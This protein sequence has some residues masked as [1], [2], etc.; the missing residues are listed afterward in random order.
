MDF[1]QFKQE[2]I[3]RIKDFLP[4]KYDDADVSIQS[5]VKNNDQK[6]DG[7]MIKTE[8]SNIAPNIYLNDF[9]K[10]LE[11]GR[12]MEDILKNIADI[13]VQNE[14]EQGF[15][16]NQITDFEQVKDKI[17]CRLVNLENNAEYLEGKPFTQIEDLAVT[18]AV[19]LSESSEGRMSVAI[20][21]NL[22]DSYGIT[23]DE[24]HQIAVD[25]IE[26]QHPEFMSMRDMLMQMMYPDGA[27][28][29]P[30]AQ[31]FLPPE[32]EKPSMYVLSNQSRVNGAAMVLDT[33]LMDDI[34]EKLGG[35]FI[36]LPSSVH[37]VIILP[38]TEEMDQRMLENM[39]QDVNA[40][41]VA[42]EE[43]LS[44]HVYAYDSQEHELI[45]ADKME[46]REQARAEKG[47]GKDKA[48][49]K[50]EMRGEKKADK[51]RTSFK[52]RL[53]EKMGEVAKN[54]AGREHPGKNLETS[55]G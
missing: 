22:M 29:D 6:L 34:A 16:V 33:K 47:L 9:F 38:K 41:Q 5:V 45:R 31:M 32:E 12:D 35:D 37:E 4:D 27:P 55:L 21:D 42:P 36:V 25:N 13:R 7:L 52:D 30:M 1:E 46:E 23:K 18:Y 54:E 26:N 24:L 53:A 51:E 20:T 49:R 14:M 40:G 15:D 11:D 8:D 48:E 50:E 19:N 28:D 17:V 10:Q 3:D 39:V 2:V 43:R 44:D